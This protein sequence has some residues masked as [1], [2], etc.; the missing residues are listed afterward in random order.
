MEHSKE[1]DS[2]S[3]MHNNMNDPTV[4]IYHVEQVTHKITIYT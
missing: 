3:I 2:I 1:D 4:V